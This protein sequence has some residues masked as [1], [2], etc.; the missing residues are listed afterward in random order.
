MTPYKLIVCACVWPDAKSHTI[1]E[2]ETPS[3]AA[4]AFVKLFPLGFA[5]PTKASR[6]FAVSETDASAHFLRFAELDPL[7]ENLYYP[8]C[9]S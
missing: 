4:M 9:R 2:F 6:Q 7:T 8:F 5:D 1:N 3:I